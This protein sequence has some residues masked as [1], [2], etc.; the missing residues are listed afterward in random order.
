MNSVAVHALTDLYAG[1]MLVFVMVLTRI[2]GLVMV[3][4]APWT[5]APVTVRMALVTLLSF[6]ATVS[7]IGYEAHLTDQPLTVALAIVSEACIGACM[8][9]TVRLVIAS[10]E[11]AADFISPQLGIGVAQLFDPHMHA[12]ETAIGSLFR[13]LAVLLTTLVGLHR[14]VL[15][16]LFGS[17]SVL[18]P[19]VVLNPGQAGG[20]V[21]ALTTTSIEAGVRIALPTVAVLF[22]VQVALAFIARAAPALQ[23]FSV[24]FAVTLGVGLLVIVLSLPDSVRI[25]LTEM[26][27]LDTRLSALLESLAEYPP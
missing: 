16:A 4:P 8:G 25:L 5:V 26:S 10:A 18:P 9:M 2:S 23:I 14:Q 12:S 20:A 21:L 17:F 24:G 13:N 19:G 15:A 6:V 1:R 27:H 22:M 3:A 11:I 7:P